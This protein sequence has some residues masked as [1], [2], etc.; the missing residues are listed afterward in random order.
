MVRYLQSGYGVAT[1]VDFCVLN[2]A[3]RR[4]EGH[5]TVLGSNLRGVPYSVDAPSADFPRV[6]GFLSNLS[7]KEM[8]GLTRYG[9]IISWSVLKPL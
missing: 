4:P 5:T 1:F 2:G 8:N 6:N 7:D 9:S 3:S